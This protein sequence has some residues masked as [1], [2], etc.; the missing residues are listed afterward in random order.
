MRNVERN[1]NPRRGNRNVFCCDYNY[2]LDHA[3]TQSW[4]SW[5]CCKCKFRFGQDVEKERLPISNEV[6]VEYALMNQDLNLDWEF[7]DYDFDNEFDFA[8]L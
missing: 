1:P 3:I 6:I 4:N 8:T 5:N 2:C 7:P